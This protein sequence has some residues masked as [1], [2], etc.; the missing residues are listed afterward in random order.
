MVWLYELV[1]GSVY[2]SATVQV[3]VY[4]VPSIL[5]AQSGVHKVY[6][7]RRVRVCA[8]FEAHFVIIFNKAMIRRMGRTLSRWS[9]LYT[10]MHSIVY[11]FIIY[12]S[13]GT[14]WRRPPGHNM[15]GRQ[16]AR[17]T[18]PAAAPAPLVAVSPAEP[19]V[20]EVIQG[21]SVGDIVLAVGVGGVSFPIGYAIGKPIRV[22]S[23]WATGFLG[24]VAGF[25]L[26]YQNSAGECMCFCCC[27]LGQPYRL[28][29]SEATVVG[30]CVRA[31]TDRARAS[32]FRMHAGGKS[33]I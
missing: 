27:T 9:V 29:V 7:V 5:S 11:L 12:S 33:G 24:S 28:R 14:L 3:P 19:D 13:T 10:V 23:M 4:T 1:Y 32:Y 15:L 21:M 31:G 16:M 17:R 25:L 26:A 22:P 20:G 30:D 2:S 6:S 18:A 8:H